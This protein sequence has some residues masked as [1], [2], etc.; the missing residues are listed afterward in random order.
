MPAV[1]WLV[2]NLSTDLV[3]DGGFEFLAV[4]AD[5][6]H[7]ISVEADWDGSTRTKLTG[8]PSENSDVYSPTYCTPSTLTTMADRRVAAENSL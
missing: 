3:D 1:S 5:D 8:K 2:E 7:L 6:K 4:A